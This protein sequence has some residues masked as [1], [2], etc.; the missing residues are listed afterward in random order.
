[1]GDLLMF[2]GTRSQPDY[3]QDREAAQSIV[4]ALLHYYHQKGHHRVKVWLEPEEQF[5]GRRFYA[6]RSN[7][8]F[9]VPQ[10]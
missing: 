9:K 7:I 4:D 3:L 5:S 10:I 8:L 1:M 2:E 6:V